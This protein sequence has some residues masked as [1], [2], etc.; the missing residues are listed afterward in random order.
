M[1]IP[2]EE[3]KKPARSGGKLGRIG[4]YLSLV[5]WLLMLV[6]VLTKPG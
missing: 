6:L 4:M 5:P 2:V 1:S 3:A